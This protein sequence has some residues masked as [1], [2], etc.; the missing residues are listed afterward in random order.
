MFTR[1]ELMN[2]M[3]GVH[4]K[5]VQY[6][7]IITAMDNDDLDETDKDIMNGYMRTVDEYQALFDKLAA[8]RAEI[9]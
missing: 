6:Q 4:A 7:D 1:S 5:I 8:M 9:I 3:L 2:L